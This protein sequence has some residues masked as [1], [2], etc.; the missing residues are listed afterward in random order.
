MPTEEVLPGSGE[1]AVRVLLGLPAGAAALFAS[2]VYA[3]SAL[4]GPPPAKAMSSAA[5]RIRLTRRHLPVRGPVP[6]RSGIQ[7]GRFPVGT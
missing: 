7:A 4:C 3:A 1:T 5:S 2:P 6:G